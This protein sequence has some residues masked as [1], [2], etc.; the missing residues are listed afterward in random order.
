[1]TAEYDEAWIA[2]SGRQAFNAL[3]VP[4]VKPVLTT[5]GVHFL[6][7]GLVAQLDLPPILMARLFSLFCMVCLLWLSNRALR[8]WLPDRNERRIAVMTAIAAPGTFFMAGMGFG[9][10]AATCLFFVGLILLGRRT[11][12]ELTDALLAGFFLGLAVSTR[13]VF[14]PVLPVVLLFVLQ[15]RETRL[16]SFLMILLT[17][18][19]TVGVFAGLFILQSTLL[20]G[21]GPQQAVSLSRNASASGLNV[22]F[23]ELSRV[24][25]FLARSAVLLPLPLIGIAALTIFALRHDKTLQRGLVVLFAVA[26]LLLLA[27]ILR[28]PWMHLRYMWPAMF[29]LNLCA[30]VGL[31]LLYR[32]ARTPEAYVLRLFAVI[33]PL[34]LLGGQIVVGLR[35]VAIGAALQVNA[36][37]YDNLENHFKPFYLIQEEAEIVNFLR[38]EIPSDAVIVTPSLPGEHG[39]LPLALLSERRIEDFRDVEREEISPD[40]VIL[41]R[42]S[43]LNTEGEKWVSSLGEP[44][45]RIK[46][47][48]V[49][50]FPQ[51]GQLPDPKEILIPS[52]LY[53]FSLTK[54]ASLTGF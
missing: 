53:R 34:L 28:S 36:S 35:L 23:P 50:A 27:W 3:A 44:Q 31:A 38:Q 40:F 51:G 42:F 32:A 30:G 14:I 49:F 15:D 20:D 47:Y 12:I 25:A 18:L 26:V 5:G 7:T 9:V 16:R 6:F 2:A 37:G 33:T 21:T 39:A 17:G 24:L 10:V 11:T 8:R 29:S 1:M 45:T 22:A 48:S 19:V 43:P 54:W 41:H 4:Q 13:W 46:G 52:Q